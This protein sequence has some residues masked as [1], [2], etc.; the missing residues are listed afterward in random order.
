MAKRIVKTPVAAAVEAATQPPPAAPAAPTAP[1]PQGP[2]FIL[3]PSSLRG[4][5]VQYLSTKPWAESN[6]LIV[7]LMQCPQFDP[8]K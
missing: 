2:G 8:P 5:L 4:A 7:G 6:D 1:A 3:L